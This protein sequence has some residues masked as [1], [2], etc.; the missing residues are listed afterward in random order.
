MKKMRTLTDTENIFKK[1]Q[2]EIWELKNTIT[3]LKKFI[4]GVQHLT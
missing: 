1:I 2:T 3:E 4:P